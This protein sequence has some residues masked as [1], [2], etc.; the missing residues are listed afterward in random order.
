MYIDCSNLIVTQQIGS[1]TNINKY[2]LPNDDQLREI[3]EFN[4]NRLHEVATYKL[5]STNNDEN[6]KKSHV[7]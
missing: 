6:P 5:W 1:D 7:N 2:F 3:E 4:T